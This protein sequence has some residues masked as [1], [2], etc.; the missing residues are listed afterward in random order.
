MN[1]SIPI[2]S[3]FHTK[4]EGECP[5][6]ISPSI[7]RYRYKLR[8]SSIRTEIPQLHNKCVYLLS[9]FFLDR[10]EHEMNKDIEGD[11]QDGTSNGDSDGVFPGQTLET[12]ADIHAEPGA[13]KDNV[14]KVLGMDPICTYKEVKYHPELYNTWFKWMIEGLPEKNKKEILETYNRRGEF[15]SEAPNLNLEIVPLLNDVAKKRDQHFADTQNCVGTAILA[16]AAAVSAILDPPEDGVD[17]DLLTD[18]ISQAGQILTEVFHQ[19]SVARKSY[20][21]PQLNKN[22]KPIVETM[23]S[24]E[25]LYGDNLKEKVKD[26]KEIE[27][28][29]ADIKEKSSLKPSAKTHDQGNG[30]Y[31][32]GKYRQVGQQQRRRQLRFKPKPYPSSQRSYKSTARATNPATSKK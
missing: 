13:A 11:S 32:P 14:L 20:I 27:K 9:P 19:Q 1:Y 15:Y 17:E 4:V 5:H 28:A 24:K 3:S 16:L 10:L 2:F 30:R 31:P 26:V 23:L 18:Y 8:I 25:W 7:R 22:I 12:C 6:G 21:T 29:C